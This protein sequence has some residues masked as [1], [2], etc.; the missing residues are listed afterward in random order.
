MSRL[1]RSFV[2]VCAVASLLVV[3]AGVGPASAKT[4][5]GCVIKA[6]TKCVNADLRGANL[7][8]AN[9]KGANLKGANL[10]GAN[11]KG[12]NL[13]G[14]NF[15]SANLTGAKMTNADLRG[16]DVEYAVLDDVNFDGADLT[17]ASLIGVQG[18]I[19]GVPKALPAGWRVFNGYL[20]GPGANLTNVD[21]A[22]EN[23]TGASLGG[24]NLT[25]ANLT[26]GPDRCEPDGRQPLQRD[27]SRCESH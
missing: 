27:F 10:K 9:L 4:I 2:A 1:S 5:N 19:N 15:E 26:R 21:F 16:A 6:K 3:G 20:V 25:G 18:F 14:A 8:G 11:L 24:A 22:G 13:K 7:K 17:G 23:I 12:A